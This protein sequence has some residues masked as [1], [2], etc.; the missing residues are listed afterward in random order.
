MSE[1]RRKEI[2]RF[3]QIVYTITERGNSV[4]IKKKKDGSLMLYEVRKSIPDR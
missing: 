2:E 1:A 3:V 4:E